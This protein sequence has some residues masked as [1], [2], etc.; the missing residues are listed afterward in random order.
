MIISPVQGTPS[1]RLHTM[2]RMA[3]LVGAGAPA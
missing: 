2:E 3:A 1:E